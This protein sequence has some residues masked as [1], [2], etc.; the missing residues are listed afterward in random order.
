MQLI[1]AEGAAYYYY[2]TFPPY[3]TH[4]AVGWNRE[5]SAVIILEIHC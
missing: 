1:E 4:S 3:I 5:V 2:Q